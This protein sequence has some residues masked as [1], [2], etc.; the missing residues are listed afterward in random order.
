MALA[1]WSADQQRRPARP[2][3]PRGDTG[4]ARW[5]RC[6]ANRVK[7]ATIRSCGGTEPRAVH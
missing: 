7:P 4:N 3:R 5:A 1:S 6:S 2:G